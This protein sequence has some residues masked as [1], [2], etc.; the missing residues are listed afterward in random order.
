MSTRASNVLR[1]PSNL[2]RCRRSKRT[3]A[4]EH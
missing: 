4:E 3:A 2:H 1:R